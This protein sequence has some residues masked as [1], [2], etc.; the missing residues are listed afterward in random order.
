[1][2]SDKE[3]NYSCNKVFLICV[4]LISVLGTIKRLH[5]HRVALTEEQSHSSM[6]CKNTGCSGYS[7]GGTGA[8]S[9]FQAAHCALHIMYSSSR[10][11]LR[12]A[13]L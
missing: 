5:P 7:N 10:V 2:P 9:R 13:C 6:N 12:T 1:M 11:D 8:H 4:G 3:N